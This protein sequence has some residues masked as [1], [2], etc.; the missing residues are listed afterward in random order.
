MKT[1]ER[2][3]TERVQHE[4]QPPEA[5]S[6]QASTGRPIGILV[7]VAVLALILGLVGGWFARGSDGDAEILLAGQGELTERQ[8]QMLDLV[9]DYEAAWHSGDGEAVA[10]FYTDRGFA[11]MGGTIYRV[12][13][14]GLQGFV[15]SSTWA[16]LD[17]LEPMLVKGDT[18]LNFHS[19]TGGTYVN[20][21]E[22]TN[23][24]ELLIVT[25][26]VSSV[27]R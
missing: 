1:M 11:D 27:F 4:V 17:V 16:S 24:G 7:L 9:R 3:S 26:T 10:A 14:G 8:E 21:T 19:Y 13:D 23:E 15:D 6:R 20:V 2:K 5:T 18:V 12:D 22:F 25:H